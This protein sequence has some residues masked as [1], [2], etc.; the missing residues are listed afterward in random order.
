MEQKIND[1]DDWIAIEKM[2]KQ[3]VQKANG[4]TENRNYSQEEA[5]AAYKI[6]KRAGVDSKDK[7]KAIEKIQSDWN[8]KDEKTAETYYRTAKVFDDIKNG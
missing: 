7:K 1:V 4:Q 6:H 8:L 2:Q 3:K 5:V